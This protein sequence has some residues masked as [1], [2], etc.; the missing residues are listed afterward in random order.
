MLVGVAAPGLGVGVA[1]GAEVE[2]DE[3]AGAV[4]LVAAGSAG[5]PVVEVDP[6]VLVVPLAGVVAGASGNVITGVGA[7]GNGCDKT[8]ASISVNPASELL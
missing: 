2:G 8:L 6:P 3:V 5:V 7:G 4:V 1:F